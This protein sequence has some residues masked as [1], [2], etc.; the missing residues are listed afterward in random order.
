MSVNL[1]PAPAPSRP[2]H[3]PIRISAGK[4]STAWATRA[5]QKNLFAAAARIPYPAR[6]P[7]HVL[8]V[9]PRC[10]KKM[11]EY[12]RINGQEGYLPLRLETKAYQRRRVTVEKPVFP[13]YCFSCFDRDG[14]AAL[15]KSNLI[16]RI[17]TPPDEGQLLRELSQI[18]K[19]L[20]VDPALAACDALKEGRQV[21][22]TGGPFAGVEGMVSSVTGR[23]KVRLNV[24]M[25]GRAVSV[26]VD[27]EYL[28]VLD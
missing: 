15:L 27:R 9:R 11:A 20:A 5:S 4:R 23:A 1:P 12:C 28:E 10:E 3:A 17:L 16:V 13:G 2:G 26:D 25:I 18:R 22:I 21:R 8:Y 24:E 6:M 19:A 14:R 7:W